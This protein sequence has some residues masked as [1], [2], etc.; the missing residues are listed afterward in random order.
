MSIQNSDSIQEE[1]TLEVL[2]ERLDK[3]VEALNSLGA[4]SNWMCEN[5]N[6]L[7]QFVQA[8]GNNGGGIRG[9]MQLL[10]QG[11]PALKTEGVPNE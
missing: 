3:V 4:Q 1:I 9:M 2:A 5:L 10:K 8:I 11:P 6:E 7:F